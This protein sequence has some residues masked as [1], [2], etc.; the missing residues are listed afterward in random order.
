MSNETNIPRVIKVWTDKWGSV[1]KEKLAKHYLP[2]SKVSVNKSEL[3][4]S[5]LSRGIDIDKGPDY[6]KEEYLK[7]FPSV[8]WQVENLSDFSKLTSDERKLVFTYIGYG[9]EPINQWFRLGGND[10]DHP[11]YTIQK[12]IEKMPPLDTDIVVYR[13]VR[14]VQGEYEPGDVISVSGYLSTSFDEF[15]VSGAV[16][17]AAKRRMK[18]MKIY[19]PKGKKAIYIPS[20]ETELL[21][22]H[23]TR[24]E[25]LRMTKGVVCYKGERE[26]PEAI[27]VRDV[28]VYEWQMLLD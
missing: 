6:I 5:A 9:Y 25:F 3:C 24:M 13:Y 26:K 20:N 17:R 12:V 28:K 14:T 16:C 21:F 4:L 22:A 23:G 18:M 11:Y 2:T 7:Q 8:E 1:T 19:V 10:K 27:Y 15:L